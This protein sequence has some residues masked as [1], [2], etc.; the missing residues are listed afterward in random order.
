[1]LVHCQWNPWKFGK[2]SVTC[3]D[4]MRT[5]TRTKR[6]HEKDG[7]SCAGESTRKVACK[8]NECPRLA[9]MP[10]Q[11]RRIMQQPRVPR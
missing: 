6:V 11:S 8:D 7:G 1:M 4:G 5:D 9:R 3:G 10:I 2:C